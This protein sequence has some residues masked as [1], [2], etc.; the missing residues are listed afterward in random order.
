[1]VLGYDS[2]GIRDCE[3]FHGV[4]GDAKEQ[5]ADASEESNDND[6]RAPLA[7]MMRKTSEKGTAKKATAVNTDEDFC[8]EAE[9]CLFFF[10]SISECNDKSMWG[11]HEQE[12][13]ITSTSSSAFRRHP[14]PKP[15]PASP[16][17]ASS[18]PIPPPAALNPLPACQN[19]P[20]LP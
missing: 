14:L 2:G 8:S 10:V 20:L 1:M 15:S 4:A 13:S 18:I 11:D 6:L 9:E 12:L 19:L 17:T 7:K 5:E 16:S 3:N